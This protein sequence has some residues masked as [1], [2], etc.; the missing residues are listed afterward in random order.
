MDTAVDKKRY[1]FVSEKEKV[2]KSSN[3][4]LL[5]VGKK[6]YLINRR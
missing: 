5:F 4:Q 1:N 3:V 6:A 2:I